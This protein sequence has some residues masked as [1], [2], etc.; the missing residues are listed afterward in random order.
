MQ[1]LIATLVSLFL[2]GPLETELADKLAAARAPRAVAIEI[3]ACAREAAPRV[4][5]RAVSDPWWAVSSTVQ[6]WI[7][8]TRP[9]AL[10]VT[11]APGCERAVQSAKPF[12]NAGEA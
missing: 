5:D 10:L 6:V 9:E 4:V 8:T 11:I 3:A 7:G 12:L 2:I 1:D